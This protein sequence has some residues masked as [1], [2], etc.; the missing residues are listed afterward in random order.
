MTKPAFT[1]RRMQAQDLPAVEHI[2]AACPEAA[3]W[4]P[5][6]YLDQ[7]SVVVTE[8]G[9]VAGFAVARQVAPD[10]LEILNLAV[11]PGYR[12]RRAGRA[13]LQALLNVPARILYLEVRA[14]NEAARKLYASAGFEESGVR[15]GYY[16]ARSGP[17]ARPEDA[18]VMKMQ[19]W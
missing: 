18:I 4:E 1:V 15:K 9:R 2:Q 12:R 7:A 11:D 5:R 3:Q 10:E 6:D 13:L 8:H 19:K 17:G 14:S 16:P